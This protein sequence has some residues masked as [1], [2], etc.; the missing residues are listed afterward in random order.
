MS[1][2]ED[3]GEWERCR[4]SRRMF[5]SLTDADQTRALDTIARRLIGLARK[6]RPG[7]P[8]TDHAAECMEHGLLDA[9]NE[10]EVAD[11]IYVVMR[12]V[13]EAFDRMPRQRWSGG[14]ETVVVEVIRAEVPLAPPGFRKAGRCTGSGVEASP[15]VHCEPHKLP[16]KG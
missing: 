1:Q 16:V 13:S 7:D 9:S 4:S 5:L 3:Q 8:A 11:R 12:A 14:G 15:S 10:K 2:I 6:F